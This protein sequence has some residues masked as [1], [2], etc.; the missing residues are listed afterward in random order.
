MIEIINIKYNTPFD[1]R[2]VFY[3]SNEVKKGEISSQNQTQEHNIFLGQYRVELRKKTKKQKEFKF[4]YVNG[5]LNLS[6]KGL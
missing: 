5:R 2:T 6:P 3:Y 4:D 1:K